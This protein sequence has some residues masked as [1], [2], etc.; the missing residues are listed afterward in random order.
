MVY[1]MDFFSKKARE[2]GFRAR[3]V[4]KLHE[5]NKKYKLI[6]KGDR[7]LDIGSYPGSWLQACVGLNCSYVLGVDIRDISP[8][9]G[10]DF[11]KVDITLDEVF[12]K[13]AKKNSEF[14]MVMSDVAPKTGGNMDAY[15]SY[16]LSSRAYEIAKR[17]LRPGGNFL[18]KIFMGP[19]F[20]SF[21]SEVRKDFLFV[22][23]I[24][25]QSSKKRSREIYIVAKT[26]KSK[27]RT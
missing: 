21:L 15:R 7:V 16:L 9:T 5:I 24:K 26:Y 22:K 3:S 1:N 25:P 19:E 12:D 17:F 6:V 11:L 14:D 27:R 20:E 8:V 2:R 23:A 4:F 18:C 13:I 10:A